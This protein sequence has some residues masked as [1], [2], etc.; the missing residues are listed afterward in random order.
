[1]V[2]GATA[3]LLAIGAAGDAWAAASDD[4][5]RPQQY[6][7]PGGRVPGYGRPNNPYGGQPHYDNPYGGDRPYYRP[8]PPP[9]AYGRPYGQ[10]YGQPYY[11]GYGRPRQLS[12]MCITSRGPCGSPP[13][14][15]GAPC[16][17]YIPGFGPKRG[18]MGY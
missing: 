13:R 8:A 11:G 10:P 1:M 3:L 17:C 16:S 15:F 9:P 7:V 18:A 12:T 5:E 6:V 2:I 4:Q 14:A